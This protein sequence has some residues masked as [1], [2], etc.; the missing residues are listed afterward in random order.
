MKT[1]KSDWFCMEKWQDS[2]TQQ[3][4]RFWLMALSGTLSQLNFQNLR[5]FTNCTLLS[6]IT[7]TFLNPK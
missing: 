2:F 1:E 7:E 3:H 6:T 5:H 4:L